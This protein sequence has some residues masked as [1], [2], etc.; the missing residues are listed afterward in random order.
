[1]TSLSIPGNFGRVDDFHSYTAT[2]LIKIQVA[3][4]DDCTRLGTFQNFSLGT[5]VDVR[6]RSDSPKELKTTSIRG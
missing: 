3:K 5:N 1:M 4:V 6:G 2:A